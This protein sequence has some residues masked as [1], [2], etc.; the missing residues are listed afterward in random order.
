MRNKRILCLLLAILMVLPLL[1]SCNKNGKPVD[2]VKNGE[3]A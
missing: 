3:S 2:I 1:A